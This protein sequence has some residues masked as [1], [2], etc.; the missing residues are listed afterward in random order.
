MDP[1]RKLA[2]RGAVPAGMVERRRPADSSLVRMAS[3]LYVRR[4]A[5]D[6]R[7]ASPLRSRRRT[8]V[9][10]ASREGPRPNPRRRWV[11]AQI[12]PLA[13]VPR[14]TPSPRRVLG[15]PQR[16]PHRTSRECGRSLERLMAAGRS[17]VC[18]MAGG[19]LNARAD[20]PIRSETCLP[21]SGDVDE[22]VED[23]LLELGLTSESQIL[24]SLAEDRLPLLRRVLGSGRLSPSSH[25]R[26]R[27]RAPPGWNG[28]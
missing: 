11:P 22:G 10:A 1:A 24:A 4:R 23:P 18:G 9:A 15:R 25:G 21:G 17:S 8:S 6:R 3:P 5:T 28:R 26:I 13:G 27:R 12:Q 19:Q 20:R 16:L 14:S 2:K 7:A